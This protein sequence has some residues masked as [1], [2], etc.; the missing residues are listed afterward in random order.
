[1]RGRSLVVSVGLLGA[2][3]LSAEASGQTASRIIDR[4]LVCTV[5]ERAGV[6]VLELRAQSGGFKEQKTTSPKLTTAPASI[7]LWT[8]FGF[9]GN[10]TELVRAAAGTGNAGSLSIGRICS[11]MKRR[12]PLRARGLP[13]GPARRLETSYECFTP[14]RVVVRVRAA[15]ATAKSLRRDPGSG[16]LFAR[17]TV[18]ESSVAVQTLRGRPILFASLKRSRTARLFLEPSCFEDNN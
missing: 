2:L 5:A 11:P 9:G 16:S 4:T 10:E 17:G 1:M 15:F 3:A 7:F 8:G 6:S 12:V 14:A 18:R 13:G